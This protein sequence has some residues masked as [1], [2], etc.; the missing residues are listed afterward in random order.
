MNRAQALAMVKAA[1]VARAAL[2]IKTHTARIPAGLC[3]PDRQ[4]GT[5][6]TAKEAGDCSVRPFDMHGLRRSVPEQWGKFC[7]THFRNA[8]DVARFF[9]T[10]EKTGRNWFEGKHAPSAAFVL[11]AVSAFPDA[12]QT[13]LGDL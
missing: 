9:D 4:A 13:L 1:P 7:R 11:R 6:P 5:E 12:V 3:C 2:C 10:D 8:D